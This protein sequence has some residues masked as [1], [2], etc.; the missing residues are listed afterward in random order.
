MNVGST[1]R[2]GSSSSVLGLTA[3]ALGFA[4]RRAWH[5]AGSCAAAQA[6]VQGRAAHW[7]IRCSD[8]R[9]F[10]RFA[11]ECF[12]MK[13]IRHE[14]NSKPCDITCNGRYNSAWSKT[15]VGYEDESFAYCLEVAYNYGV[16][17]YEVGS[18]L[19]S[20]GLAVPDV[21]ASLAKAQE[22]GF[23][24]EVATA[25]IVGPDRYKRDRCSPLPPPPPW[26]SAAFPYDA[27]RLLWSRSGDIVPWLPQQCVHAYGVGTATS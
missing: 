15:M 4:V 7:V 9:P 6:Q 22:M 19:Q 16:Y 21:A 10:L 14:E 18:A 8:L 1:G 2:A 12:G 20:I 13:V 17:D 25:T 11:K 5:S 26:A 23:T 24:V 27:A 3:A